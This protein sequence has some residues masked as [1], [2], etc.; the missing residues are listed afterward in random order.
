MKLKFHQALA[1]F[2]FLVLLEIVLNPDIRECNT[3]SGH[4]VL[5]F[6]HIISV[7][8]YATPFLF[9]IYKIHL[10]FIIIVFAGF[11][12]FKRCWIT[13]MH[14]YLCEIEDLEK[15]KNIHYHV[16]NLFGWN[17]LVYH[18]L[19]HSCLLLYDVYKIMV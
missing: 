16:S 14:N 12:Y 5:V 15:F 11:F 8:G 2:A 18:N 1:I 19:L 17:P 9:A 6:H 13:I 7:F 4:I 3:I 10:A